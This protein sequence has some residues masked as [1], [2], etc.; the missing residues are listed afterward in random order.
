MTACLSR[1]Y[2]FELAYFDSRTEGDTASHLEH[3]RICQAG[4]AKARDILTRDKPSRPLPGPYIT[5]CLEEIQ[6]AQT[7]SKTDLIFAQSDDD[8]NEQIEEEREAERQQQRDMRQIDRLYD[9]TTD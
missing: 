1:I 7:Q 5:R 2:L 6:M 3:C 9:L 4:L 8:I